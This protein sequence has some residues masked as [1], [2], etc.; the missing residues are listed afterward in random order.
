MNR[1]IFTFL[2]LTFFTFQ[3][4]AQVAFWEDFS[5]GMPDNFVLVDGDG[6][7]PAPNVSYV[8]KAWVV[9]AAGS[10]TSTSWYSPAGTSDD[11]MITSE[12]TIPTV[13]AD[14]D[15]LLTWSELAPDKDYLDGYLLKISTSGSPDVDSF[16]TVMTTEEAANELTTRSLDLKPYMGMTVRFAY[17]N[18]SNDKFLLFIDD[19]EVNGFSDEFLDLALVDNLSPAFS[20]GKTMSFGVFC[21]GNYTE[22]FDVTYTVNGGDPITESITPASA[23]YHGSTVD[24]TLAN[25]LPAGKLNINAIVSNVNGLAA[26]ADPTNDTLS[27]TMIV[28]DKEQAFARNSL[29]EVF[30]S[31][32]C[33]PCKPGNEK[34]KTIVGGMDDKP[35][36]LKYQQ[37]F[38]GTGDPYTTAETVERRNHYGI[39]AIPTTQIDGLGKTLNPNS[40][41]LSDITTAQA[42]PALANITA[43]Y[44]IDPENQS[45]RVFGSYTAIVDLDGANMMIAIK[46][47]TTTKNVKSNDETEFDNVVKKLWNG[48]AGVDLAG[49]VAGTT[50]DFD[51]TYEFKGDYKLPTDGQAANNINHDIQHSVED[52]ENLAASVFIEVQDESYILQ[53]M[54]ADM[55]VGTNDI[56]ALNDVKTYPN[57]STDYLTIDYTTTESMP[58]SIQV[59][60]MAG[61]LVLTQNLGKVPVGAHSQTIDLTSLV[62][63]SYDISILSGNKG[64]STTFVV[65]K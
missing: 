62:N 31:S 28:Y 6:N 8:D 38:P 40:L 64:F 10:A 39:N 2:L 36:L 57:P 13:A 27:F 45:I 44:Q 42:E 7:T 22:S 51:Y 56:V 16:V 65:A 26:D 50:Y 32:T 33:G 29:F 37:N 49:K 25:P 19:I 11:W 41:V 61:R 55:V 54:E 1:S 12:I 35:I 63:G 60:D 9:N 58:L 48:T 46:E 14:V 21:S 24:I 5:N 47:L 3:L 30:T 15:L 34:V 23:F 4:Q 20:E 18:N 43:S 53:A 52:F 59:V 17:V